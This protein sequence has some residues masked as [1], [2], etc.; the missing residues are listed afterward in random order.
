MSARQME[1]F[2]QSFIAFVTSQI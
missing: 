2:R 1:G